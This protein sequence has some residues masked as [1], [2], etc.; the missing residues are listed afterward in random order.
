MVNDFGNNCDFACGWA[1]FEEDH[2]QAGQFLSRFGETKDKPRPTSTKRLKFE[3]CITWYQR[4][5]IIAFQHSEIL[6]LPR[7]T[8]LV[9]TSSTSYHEHPSNSGF[10]AFV[11]G[12]KHH[13]AVST[14]YEKCRGTHCHRYVLTLPGVLM[15]LTRSVRVVCDYICVYLNA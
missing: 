10:S 1:R 5:H 7:C 3:S 13:L 9:R 6:W 2:C 4:L 8:I 14:E 11:S 12:A 15:S